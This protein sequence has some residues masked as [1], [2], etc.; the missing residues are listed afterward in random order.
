ME[1]LKHFGVALRKTYG[2][3]FLID[4]NVLKKMVNFA[5]VSDKDILL[6][7]GSGIGNLTEISFQ[8]VKK[9]IA[10]EI[11]FALSE[12]FEKIFKDYIGKKIFLLKKDAMKLNYKEIASTY[13]I[14]KCVS[15]LPYK[16]AAPILL[17]ILSQAPEITD[18]F[19]TIQ[20][21]IADRILAKPG[22]KNY[23]AFSVKLNFY[24]H[25]VKSFMISRNC[26]YPKPYVDSVTV[27]IKRNERF[28]PNRVLY[29]IKPAAL[30]DILKNNELQQLF[31]S[32]FFNFVEDCFYHRRKKLINSLNLRNKFYKDNKQKIIFFLEKSGFLKDARPEDLSLETLLLLFLSIKE[33]YN[34]FLKDEIFSSEDDAI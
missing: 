33:E 27:H 3:N 16:I 8:H 6:E 29:N 23:N 14:N 1:I 32:H 4:T 26:F 24:S 12:I 25:Y 34:Y 15:N 21:D 17:K 7:I 19:V 18:F 30:S 13:N 20:K 2:Q 5:E 22:D 10:V 9:I 28:L 31:T 11:D